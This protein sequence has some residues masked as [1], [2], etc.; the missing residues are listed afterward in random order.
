MYNE[1]RVAQ[2]SR[3]AGFKISEIL[4]IVKTALGKQQTRFCFPKAFFK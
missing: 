3:A 1:L 2:D 4:N